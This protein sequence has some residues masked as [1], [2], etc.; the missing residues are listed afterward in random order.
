MI[1]IKSAE[2]IEL[3]R[4]SSIIVS[5][6]LAEVA[7]MIKPGITTLELDKKAEEFILDNKAKPGFKGYK[8]Y[9]ATLCTSINSEVVH[10]IPSKYVLKEGDIVSVDC[11]V[12][13]NG[14]Y[15]DSAYTFAV[16]QIKEDEKLL[17]ETTKQ[18]LFEGIKQAVTGKRIGDIGNAVQK[19]CEERGLSVVREMVGHGMGKHLHEE[20]EVPNYGKKGC[21]IL[22][23][24]GMVL[25][26][27]PMINMGKRNIIQ[28]SDGWTIKTIDNKPSAHFEL[29][30]A[31]DNEKADIL[32][33]FGFIE[34]T[35]YKL[36]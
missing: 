4:E 5:K 15:G 8:G 6:T 18:S 30:V 22:L 1:L 10:G 34:N 27:E 17:L 25:C 9:P 36:K 29:T 7:E 35:T 19:Y 11:G 26:I 12:I 14:Y 32:S 24:K 16:G 13:K 31:V 21:G 28:E 2:E 3:I 20:P 33:T 23:K